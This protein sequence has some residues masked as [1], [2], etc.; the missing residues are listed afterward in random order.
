ML[1]YHSGESREGIRKILEKG[2]KRVYFIGIGGVS[3]SSLAL[4]LMRQGFTV[5]GSDRAESAN[6]SRLRA[7][8]AEITLRQDGELLKACAPSLVAYSL[9]VDS[10]NGDYAAAVGMNIPT[11][12]RAELMGLII[13]S[14]PLSVGVSGSHGKSTVTALIT[15]IFS[16]AK[17]NPTALLGA[18]GA[19]GACELIGGE[20]LVIYESCEY[21]NSFLNMI[22]THQLILNC[23]LDHTDFFKSRGE[24]CESFARCAENA[25]SFVFLPYGTPELSFARE[26]AEGKAVTYGES[27]DADYYY[28]EISCQNGRYSFA[29][30]SA[31]VYLGEIKMSIAGRH[32]MENAVAAVA[33]A[34]HMGVGFRICKRAVESFYGIPRRQEH[35]ATLGKTAVIYDYA[36]HPKEI[37][38]TLKSLRLTGYGRIA[39]IFRPHTYSRTASL[40]PEFSVALSDADLAVITDIYAAREQPVPGVS[41]RVLAEKICKS[42]GN[43]YYMPEMEVAERLSEI[44]SQGF[45]C[46][47]LMGAGNLDIIKSKI[48]KK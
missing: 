18:E 14:F 2:N 24:L 15:H 12:S 1:L 11:V 42:G 17:K 31:G 3:M 36:H 16:E 20:E 39:V 37:E 40:M 9:S 22:P 19:D 34:Y 43:A 29:F 25:R 35:I 6:I 44:L 46:I 38:A 33:V 5:L 27:P 4:L 21:K 47:I 26:R 41:S 30:S 32:N 23:D 48:I 45:D 8:G 10:E 28:R 7:A 13:D